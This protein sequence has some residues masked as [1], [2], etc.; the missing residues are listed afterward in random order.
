WF[1]FKPDG[2]ARTALGSGREPR[3]TLAVCNDAKHIIYG[4]FRNGNLEL[5]RSDADGSNAPQL[6]SES[7]AGLLC[8]PDSKSAI[9]TRN[10]GYWRVSIDG[11]K[12]EKTDIPLTGLWYSADGKLRALLSQTVA[13][14]SISS[15]IIVSAADGGAP[16]Y[17]LDAPYGMRSARF[18]PDG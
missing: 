11:G 13:G 8:A 9:Y 12:P 14:G 4:T 5:W 6:S 7:V 1:T 2:S 18:T 10:D 17:K 3:V 15:Q 16:L